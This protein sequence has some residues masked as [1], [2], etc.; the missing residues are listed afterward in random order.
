MRW[1]QGTPT[2]TSVQ[3]NECDIPQETTST[4]IL[5]DVE[6]GHSYQESTV[7]GRESLTLTE[8]TRTRFYVPPIPV[9]YSQAC[10]T[11]IFFNL[12]LVRGQ[13][14]EQHIMGQIQLLWLTLEKCGSAKILGAFIF[15][16]VS[17]HALCTCCLSTFITTK[18]FV[19]KVLTSDWAVWKMVTS[20][21]YTLPFFYKLA[22]CVRKV[23]RPCDKFLA[24][25]EGAVS[26]YVCGT[27]TY[28]TVIEFLLE[29]SRC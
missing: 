2:P 28:P 4:K 27:H 25:H 6:C 17:A 22:V 5:R 15:R 11:F 29:C 9:P 20:N 18:E 12:T 23:S 26:T 8:L 13:E 14:K 3:D 1:I 24:P 10:I 19:T 7:I 16:Q 21:L